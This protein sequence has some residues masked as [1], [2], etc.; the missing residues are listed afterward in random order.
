M[1][2][3]LSAPRSLVALAVLGAAALPGL[4][5]A[6]TPPQAVAA[7]CPGRL[8]VTGQGEAS[9]TPDLLRVSLRTETEAASPA[10]ALNGTAARAEAMLKALKDQG[11]ADV[12]VQTTEVSLYPVRDQAKPG[13]A[14]NIVAWRAANGLRVSLVDPSRFGS[15]VNAA[16]AAGATEVSGISLEVS[17][18]EALLS[19]ARTRAVKDAMARAEA[20][21]TAAGLTLGDVVEMSDASAIP[22]PRPMFARAAMADEAMPIAQGEQTL[23]ASVNMTFELCR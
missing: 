16:A 14:P 1:P 15:V 5:A 18:P 20:L 6:Q 21:A 3:P 11:I 19:E 17:D 13:K 12:D 23:S 8:A 7:T 2:R 9:G 10:D 4:A 22:G